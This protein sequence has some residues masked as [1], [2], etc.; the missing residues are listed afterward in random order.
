MERAGLRRT[1]R[2]SEATACPNSSSSFIPGM[3]Q[4]LE[5]IRDQRFPR[6]GI[7]NPVRVEREGG[8][9]HGFSTIGNESIETRLMKPHGSL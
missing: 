1:P 4:L 9:A 8:A 2:K 6:V 3:Q 7:H 5:P